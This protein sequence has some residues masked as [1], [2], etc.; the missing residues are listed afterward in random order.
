MATAKLLVDAFKEV[1]DDVCNVD[2]SSSMKDDTSENQL[3]GSRED[4]LKWLKQELSRQVGNLDGKFASF[5]NF[6]WIIMP[7]VL[8][9]ENLCIK[10]SLAH[11]CL[12]PGE[13]HNIKSKSKGIRG[14]TQKEVSI[15]VE[16]LKAGTMFVVKIPKMS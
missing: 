8:A 4:P 2:T 5:K 10:G 1:K 9:N 3:S 14:L 11:K 13:Y 7:S 12:L 6:P 16:A 15:L